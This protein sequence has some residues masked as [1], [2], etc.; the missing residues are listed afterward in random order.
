[1]AKAKKNTAETETSRSIDNQ[2][3]EFLKSGGE[4]EHIETGVSGQLSMAP[5]KHITLGNKST[6]KS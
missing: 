3:K 2:I 5:N 1:M 4:I 6:A